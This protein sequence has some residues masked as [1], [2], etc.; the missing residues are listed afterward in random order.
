MTEIELSPETTEAI[1]KRTA[2]LISVGSSVEL[3]PEAIEAIARRVAALLDTRTAPPPISQASS[4]TR[5]R[6]IRSVIRWLTKTPPRSRL[7]K[8]TEQKA[9]RRLR[10]KPSFK[11]FFVIWFLTYLIFPT[12]LP[13]ILFSI[14]PFRSRNAYLWVTVGLLVGIAPV[15]LSFMFRVV[16]RRGHWAREWWP[17]SEYSARARM[18][19]SLFNA[20]LVLAGYATLVG[21]FSATYIQLAYHSSACFRGTLTQA[22]AAYFTITT[23]TTT[24]FG[25]IHPASD[26]CRL[27]V[28]GQTLVGLVVLV[29]VFAGLLTRLIAYNAPRDS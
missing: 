29:V 20:G 18:Q 16:L 5:L 10:Y 14:E 15:V 22:Q 24:G 7:I 13:W 2:E 28:A 3:K 6:R 19:L 25:D 4:T 1:A 9:R 11:R 26:G 8:W 23:F 27:A 21:L 17:G 12:S